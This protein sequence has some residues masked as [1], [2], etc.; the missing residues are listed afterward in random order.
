MANPILGP[1]WNQLVNTLWPN[2]SHGAQ[3]DCPNPYCDYNLTRED[4]ND[5]EYAGGA[6]QCPQCGWQYDLSPQLYGETRDRTRSGMSLAEM[7]QLGEEVVK[8]F[9]DENGQ[10]PGIGPIR[11]ESPDYQDPIDLVAGNYALEVKSLHSE[12]YPRFKI[13]ADPSSG[14]NRSATIQGKM[15]RMA[16]LSQHLGIPLQ[17]AMLGVRLN[18]YTNRADFFFAPEYRDRMMTNMTHVGSTDFSKLNPFQN[19]EDVNQQALPAQGET[20]DIPF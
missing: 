7:G 18:F 5:A 14:K 2:E 6:F 3:S 9:A 20:S 1:K 19:P 11:W 4:I 8:Q 13:A 15:E 12:S 16:Q 10:I 17:P